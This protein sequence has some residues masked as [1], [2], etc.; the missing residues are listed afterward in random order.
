MKFNPMKF[1]M[2][3]IEFNTLIEVIGSKAEIA[4]MV[5]ADQANAAAGKLG[6]ADKLG[7]IMDKVTGGSTVPTSGEKQTFTVI[8]TVDM[9]KEFTQEAVKVTVKDIKSDM[10]A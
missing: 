3:G 2:N 5:A 7:G 4:K 9:L 8:V 1:S 10:K 6:V